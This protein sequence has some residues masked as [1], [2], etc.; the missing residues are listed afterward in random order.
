MKTNKF[1]TV[2]VL[3]AVALTFA[4]GCKKRSP[5]DEEKKAAQIIKQK[6]LGRWNLT[7]FIEETKKAD[8]SVEV[9]DNDP[10]NVY[11]EFFANDKGKTNAEGEEEFTYK[12][13]ANNVLMLWESQQNIVELTDNKLTF[14]NTTTSQGITYT[15]TYYLTR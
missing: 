1:L 10:K 5:L 4:A 11:F 12:M 3:L 2:L 6:I 13:K 14:K 7:D 9:V 15:Q 8:G